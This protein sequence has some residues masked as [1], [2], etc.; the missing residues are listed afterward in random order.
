LFAH[1]IPATTS[2]TIPTIPT[3]SF[4]ILCNPIICMNF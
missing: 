3:M 4:K 1:T 2:A